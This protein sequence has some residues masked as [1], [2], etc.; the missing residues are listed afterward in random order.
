ME[1]HCMS[2]GWI[3]K[4]VKV[5]LEMLSY[6]QLLNF[7]STSAEPFFINMNFSYFFGQ[8]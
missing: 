1:G 5:P 8:T 6:G 2:L 3:S 4:Y 7:I